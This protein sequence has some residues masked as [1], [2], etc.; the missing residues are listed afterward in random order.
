MQRGLIDHR[1]GQERVAVVFQG[2]GQAPKPV[3]PLAAQMALDS[4][5]IDQWLSLFTCLALDF[6]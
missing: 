4:D 2:E 6:V 3:C 1:A 5:L